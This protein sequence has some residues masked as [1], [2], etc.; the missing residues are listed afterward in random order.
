MFSPGWLLQEVASCRYVSTRWPPQN[1]ISFLQGLDGTQKPPPA[2]GWQTAASCSSTG[3]ETHSSTT[4]M[5]LWL[6]SK[7]VMG[8]G[9]VRHQV[10]SA[11][12]LHA[13]G[14]ALP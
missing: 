10:T 5:P 3:G 4:E 2:P 12:P 6:F 13:D 9:K 11:L 8:F 14:L 1:A 7:R